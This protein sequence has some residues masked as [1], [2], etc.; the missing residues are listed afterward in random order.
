MSD[1]NP[2]DLDFEQPDQNDNFQ[3]DGD[4]IKACTF[5]KLIEKVTHPSL[6]LICVF[7]LIG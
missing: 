7:G 3:G 2:F 4:V 5:D 1:I 6:R